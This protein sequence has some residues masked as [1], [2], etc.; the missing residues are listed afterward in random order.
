MITIKEAHRICVTQVM[1][2]I[3]KIEF[4]MI[5]S[6]LLNLPAKFTLIYICLNLYNLSIIYVQLS[7][8][9]Y[10]KLQH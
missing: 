8:P 7:D 3:K 9:G 6:C 5:K 10:M 2:E 4:G 1:N